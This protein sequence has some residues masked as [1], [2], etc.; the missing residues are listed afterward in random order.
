MWKH[1]NRALGISFALHIVVILAVSPFFVSHFDAE[2]ESISA[3]ILTADPEKRVK[4]Q[5]LPPR[6]RL[7]ARAVSEEAAS[8]APAAPT[9][10]PR[11]STPKAPIHADIVPDV[12][13]HADLPQ[14]NNSTAVSNA[15]F[16]ED[17]TL[18]GP[19]VIKG[20]QGRGSGGAGVGFEG[21]E[22]HGSSIGTQF[23]QRTGVSEVRS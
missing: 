19:V 21:P 22:R 11:V 18:G 9:Y 6:L 14:T 8:D 5:I 16:G 4:R 13:T 3:E 23:A 10:A 7:A 1:T 15:S 2:K 12:V 17:S 20:Q